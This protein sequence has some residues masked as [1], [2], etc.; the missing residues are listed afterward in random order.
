MTGITDESGS[1]LLEKSYHHGALTWQRFANGDVCRYRDEIP[2]SI[3]WPAGPASRC[4][5]VPN[6]IFLHVL[7]CQIFSVIPLSIP[8]A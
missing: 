2:P 6:N 5:I 7:W 3:T 4:P 1:V 8:E